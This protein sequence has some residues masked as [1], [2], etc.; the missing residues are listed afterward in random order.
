MLKPHAIVD[1]SQVDRAL[2]DTELRAKR[3]APA[4]RELR[5][6]LR[7]DQRDHAKGEQGSDGKWPARSP[8]TEA[9]R[10]A[11]SRASRTTRALRTIALGRFARRSTPRKILGRL[12]GAVVYT[13]G[14]LF[15]RATSRAKKIGPA[16]QFGLR[17]GRRLAVRLH[18]REFL[19]L[20]DKL[21]DASKQV[22]AKFVVK[23]WR[24]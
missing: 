23:G 4:F 1:L 16:H 20:S 8:L 15:A 2:A 17:V 22:L 3:M 18:A 12:P 7:R 19:W 6:L 10:K 5:P 9:R 24:R 21:L 11:K 14:E 13:V